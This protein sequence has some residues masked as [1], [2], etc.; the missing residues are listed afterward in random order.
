MQVGSVA[1]LLVAGLHLR[2]CEYCRLRFEATLLRRLF[3][4]RSFSP[5]LCGRCFFGSILGGCF[6]SDLC[7]GAGLAVFG[8]AFLAG[9][10]LLPL[11]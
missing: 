11:F 9:A 3:W 7:N 2:R 4:L 8:A 10:S 5:A 1:D 6:L